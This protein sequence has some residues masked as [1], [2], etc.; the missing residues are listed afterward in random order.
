MITILSQDKTMLIEAN[1]VSLTEELDDFFGSTGQ[2]ETLANG[3]CMGVYST[4]EKTQKVMKQIR[5]FI[6]KGNVYATNGVWL[7]QP[8]FEVFEMPQDE[9]V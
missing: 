1:E 2:Y 3:N 9:E 5:D 4:L 8:Q 6:N 7:K